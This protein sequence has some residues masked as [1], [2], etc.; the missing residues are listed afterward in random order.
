MN[1]DMVMFLLQ[2]SGISTAVFAVIYP[3][4]WIENKVKERQIVLEV[5]LIGI[6]VLSLWIAIILSYIFNM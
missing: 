6:S 2:F 5:L 3:L 4:C 1:L